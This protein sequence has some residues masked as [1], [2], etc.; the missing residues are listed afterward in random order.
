M[1]CS[2]VLGVRSRVD[3]RLGLRPRA[4]GVRG[5]GKT[6]ICTASGKKRTCQLAGF[7]TGH[8]NA[9]ERV[10]GHVLVASFRWCRRSVA[11]F[12]AEEAMTI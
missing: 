9:L 8:R 12:E 2:F 6:Y 4:R 3:G 5:F 11:V 7:I 1:A 10:S